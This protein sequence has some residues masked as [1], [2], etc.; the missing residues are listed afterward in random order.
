MQTGRHKIVSFNPSIIGTGSNCDVGEVHTG[1]IEMHSD[2]LF[3][4]EHTN[5]IGGFP[6]QMRLKPLFE[7]LKTDPEIELS[8]FIFRGVK[9]GYDVHITSYFV[10]NY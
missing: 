9:Y 10:P 3:T 8:K 7:E 6:S 2:I 4:D 1:F 5:L